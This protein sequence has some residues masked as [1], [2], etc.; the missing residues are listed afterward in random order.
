MRGLLGAL[1]S[2]EHA[3]RA[4][5]PTLAQLEGLLADARAGGR[6]IDLDVAGD[7]RSLSE[8][9]ELAAYRIVEHALVAVATDDASVSVRLHYGRDALDVE[10]EGGHR[11]GAPVVEEPIVAAREQAAVRGGSFSVRAAGPGR[12]TLCA[13]LPLVSEHA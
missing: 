11:D 2:D 8:A 5:R 4:P 1:R 6:V 9:V 13:R 7:R 10:V 12:R 3:A